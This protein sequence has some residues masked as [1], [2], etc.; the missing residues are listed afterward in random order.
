MLTPDQIEA[1]AQTY[2]DQAG[3]ILEMDADAIEVV[4]NCELAPDDAFAD[5]LKLASQMT[6]ARMLERDTF[7]KR[8][9]AGVTI[10]VHEFLYPLMQG[11]DSRLHPRRRRTWR[12]RPDV[13]Q[14]GRPRP[15]EGRRP[16][17]RRS[18]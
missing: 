15:P 10:Y 1:N 5:A 8:Y 3:K 7:E 6:V 9:K 14:P 17:R 11:Y 16:G 4:R 13:Q 12:H 18:S 2:F